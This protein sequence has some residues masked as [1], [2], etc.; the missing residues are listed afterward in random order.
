MIQKY[1]NGRER[2]YCYRSLNE[3]EDENH[4]FFKCPLHLTLKG[5]ICYS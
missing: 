4:F 1:Q 3:I 5:I 2:I